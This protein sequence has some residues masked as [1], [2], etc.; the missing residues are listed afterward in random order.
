VQLLFSDFVTVLSPFY[1][2]QTLV[3]PIVIINLPAVYFAY[4]PDIYLPE[5]PLATGQ[6]KCKS[7]SFFS[8]GCPYANVMQLPDDELTREF[9]DVLHVRELVGIYALDITD[10][11]VPLRIKILR[12]G[13]VYYGIASLA[14]REKGANDYYRDSGTYPSKEAALHGAVAGFFLHLKPGAS[15][16]EIKNWSVF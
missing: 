11:E 3:T 14:V 6:L 2:G 7:R 9:P 1:Q 10:V 13:S 5:S 15:I 12:S 8:F 4:G 16:R